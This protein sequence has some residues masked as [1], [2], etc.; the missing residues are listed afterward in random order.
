MTT[1]Y[2]LFVRLGKKHCLVV[3]LGEV[4]RRKLAA[5]LAA[6]PRSVLAVEP[7]APD[8]ELAAT[9]SDPRV[10]FAHRP[11]RESDV[12]DA[13]LVFAATDDPAVNA[14]IAQAA[15][16]ERAL[17]NIA[18]DPDGSD[19]FVP[20]H[21][22]A[23]GV[24]VALSTGGLSPAFAR[25]LR[26]DLQAWFGSRYEAPITF[27]GRFRPALLELGLPSAENTRIFR[28]LAGSELVEA[29]AKRDREAV[30]TLLRQNAP[31]E[32]VPQLADMLRD[33]V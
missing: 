28:A 17:V 25:V 23:Q 18:D 7:N 10:Q 32:L 9:L 26:Q 2:P 15:R 24:L 27:M 30:E 19:F 13:T 22:E 5:L 31:T 4:G 29:F 14:R 33:L 1:P 12:K 20:A 21:F 11:F 8:A 3:G 6:K 16:S